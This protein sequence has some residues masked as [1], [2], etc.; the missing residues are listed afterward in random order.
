MYKAETINMN[1]TEMTTPVIRTKTDAMRYAIDYT[2][3]VSEEGARTPRIAEAKEIFRLFTE[4]IDLPDVEAPASAAAPTGGWLPAPQP[5]IAEPLRV[6]AAQD[7]Y[8]PGIYVPD[9]Q[10]RLVPIAEW[11][12]RDGS[13]LAQ[14]LVLITDLVALEIAKTDMPRAYSYAESLCVSNGFRCMTLHEAIEIYASRFQGLDAAFEAIGGTPMKKEYWTCEKDQEPEY[15]QSFVFEFDAENGT[16]DSV[17]TG[18]TEL[19]I[20]PVRPLP[21]K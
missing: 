7:R 9:D 11:K 13:A 12:R 20:R 15:A 5:A 16:I 4:N 3:C 1:D 19:F 8:I 14:T 10:R 2:S 6:R 21:T 18:E 17:P